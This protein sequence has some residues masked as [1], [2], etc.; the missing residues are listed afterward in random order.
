M[1]DYHDFYCKVDTIQLADIMEHQ[2]GRLMQT[3]GLDILHSYTPPG[4]S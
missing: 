3:H 2:R 1:R 4:F